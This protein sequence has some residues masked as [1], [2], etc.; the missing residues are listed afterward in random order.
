MAEHPAHIG[1]LRSAGH[2]MTVHQDI[3]FFGQLRG[4]PQVLQGVQDGLDQGFKI[5]QFLLG[6][7]GDKTEIK[8]AG[9]MLH[10]SAPG[11]PS[12][13]NNA[14][15]PGEFMVEFLERILVPADDNGR[16][17]DIKQQIFGPGVQ[18]AQTILFQGQI[19]GGVG[20]IVMSDQKHGQRLIFV[21]GRNSGP[22]SALLRQFF[23]GRAVQAV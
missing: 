12:H 16:P 14:L 6:E 2:L 5:I 18:A 10:R 1:V 7:I 15:L 22:V 11:N 3:I 17:V 4:H 19:C 23:Q 13:R 20:G 21:G 8:V 9:D